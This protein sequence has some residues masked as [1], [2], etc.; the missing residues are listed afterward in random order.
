MD[1]SPSAL[2]LD[3]PDIC[4]KITRFISDY[5]EKIGA[6]GVVLGLSGGID[7]STVVALSA[8][9]LGGDR[10]LGLLLPEKETYAADDVTHAM[11]TAKKFKIRT[12]KCDITPT[13]ETFTI[14]FP[15]LILQKG[16]VRGT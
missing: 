2:A 5:V 14:R 10:V 1:L 12:E 3:F 6:D 7:S 4:G 11:L 8:L 9:A 16:S 15:Y 13:L